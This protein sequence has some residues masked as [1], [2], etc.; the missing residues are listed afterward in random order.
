MNVEAFENSYMLR[1]LMLLLNYKGLIISKIAEI[2]GVKSRGGITNAI[3][4]LEDLELVTAPKDAAGR[5]CSLTTKGANIARKLS[6][7]FDED[8]EAIST[9]KG[10]YNK[11]QTILEKLGEGTVDQFIYNCI[12][13]K[14]KMHKAF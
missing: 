14:I 4:S 8:L 3:N 10:M 7:V 5:Y 2:F 1:I 11:L 13:E 12:N 9:P 6:Y